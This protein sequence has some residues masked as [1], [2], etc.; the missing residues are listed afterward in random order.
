MIVKNL[1]YCKYLSIPAVL[2]LSICFSITTAN[3]ENREMNDFT[4]RFLENSEAQR[5][6]WYMGAFTALGH[7]VSQTNQKQADCIYNWYFK[8]PEKKRKIIEEKF[9]KFPKFV[10]SSIILGLLYKDCGKFKIQYEGG[11]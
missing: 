5:T 1:H 10:P 4:K 6:W 2:L 7:L 8:E 11:M 9:P 3:A